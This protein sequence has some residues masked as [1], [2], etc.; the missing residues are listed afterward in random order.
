MGEPV[1]HG[2]VA[3][4][5]EPVRAAFVQ[6]VKRGGEIGAGLC[7]THRGE[8]VVDLWAGV[9]DRATGRP[10][11]PDTL[12]VV[13][14]VTKGMAATALLMLAD[15]GLLDYDRPVAH[16]WPEFA[17][18]GKEAIT[19][20]TLLC[21]RAGLVAL[22][23]PLTLD[24]FEQ[25]PEKVA[26]ACAEQHPF[27][28]PGTDQGYHGV[29]Y[30]PYVAELFRRV[31]GESIGTFLAREVAGPLG[32]DVYLGAPEH[33]RDRVATNYPVGKVEA[34]TQ[35]IP[36]L[37]LHRGTEGRVYRQVAFKGLAAKAFGNPPELGAKGMNNWNDPR[38][39]RLELPW[40]NAVA[41][42]R[43]LARVYAALANGGAVDGVRL[44]QPEV[45]EPLFAR[46]SWSERDRILRRPMGWSQGFVKEGP[47]IFSPNLESFGHPG[48]GGS[49]GWCD[50][51]A[52]VSIGYVINRMGHHIRSP[53]ALAL[54]KA[55]YASPG[56]Q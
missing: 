25:R 2:T 41:S 14:S 56:L 23:E 38:V 47:A 26:R 43:G 11:G 12:N 19:V 35:V 40:A 31:A 30:G 18:H 8:T 36:K 39:Q 28:A 34:A 51:K 50:P 48:A 42:A 20:R 24:D 9:A 13:F 52:R 37:L 49:L 4:G 33:V 45:I 22:D 44:V 29:T 53:R 3:A 16:Y 5:F 10:W 27:W 54:C 46:Q 17:A 21:H 15:R 7:I 6:N 55:L 1:I 32:A